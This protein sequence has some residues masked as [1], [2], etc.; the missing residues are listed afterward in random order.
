VRKEL[1]DLKTQI[2]ETPIILR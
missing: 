1:S 2:S